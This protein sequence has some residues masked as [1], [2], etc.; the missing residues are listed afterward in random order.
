MVLSSERLRAGFDKIDRDLL[1]LMSCFREVLC[2]LGEQA[3][4]DRLPWINEAP[5]IQDAEVSTSPAMLQAVSISF[6]L[7]NMVE[8]NTSNQM[9]RQAERE[10]GVSAERGLWGW[11]LERLKQTGWKAADV[12]A[13]LPYLRVE[14]VLTAHPTEAKRVTVMEQHRELYVLLIE[15]ENQMYTPM[16]RDQIDNQIKAVLERLWRTGET[17]LEKPTVALERAT[18]LH[19]L[20]NVFPSAVRRSDLNLID[21]WKAVG[22]DSEIIDDPATWPRI[23][24]GTWVGG[25]RDGHPLV[26]PQVTRESL[27]D[28][29]RSALHLLTKELQ[30]LRSKL[31][32]S[33]NLQSPPS[34]LLSALD[35]F[36]ATCGPNAASIANRNPAEPWR[37]YLSFVLERLPPVELDPSEQTDAGR[38]YHYGFELAGDLRR[39]RSSLKKVGAHRVVTA[40]LDPVLR[41]AEVFGFHLATLD[42]R[43][44]SGY[45]DTAI[46]QILVAAGMEET[47][48][49]GWSEAAKIDFFNKH[50]NDAT[51]LLGVADKPGKEAE[52]AIGA[53]REVARH[54]NLYGEEGIGSIILSM[55]RSPADLLALY[56]LA[57]EAGLL[58]QL[59]F[60]LVC[61]VPLVPLLETID[62]LQRGPDILDKFLAHPISQNSHRWHH[63]RNRLLVKKGADD[64]SATMIPDE[65]NRPVQQVMVGYSDS[66]K[67]S[68]ILSSQWNLFTSQSAIAKTAARHGCRVRFFHGRGGTISRGAGPTH[69]F[70]EA[71]P[72]GTIN[73]DIRLTEQ[74]ETIGQKYANTLTASHN[75]TLLLSGTAYCSLQSTRIPSHP[76]KGLDQIFA[77]LADTSRETYQSLLKQPGFIDFYATAT[78]L[79]VLERSRIGSRP[80]RRSGARTLDDLR[81]IPWV[82]SWSQARFF[83]PGWYGV[84]KAL[85]GLSEADFAQLSEALKTWPFL[86]YVMTNVETA[87]CSADRSLMERYASL[88]PDE[89]LRKRF[90]E[91][92]LEEYESVEN[93]LLKLFGTPQAERRPRLDKTLQPRAKA[94]EPL[95][96]RQIELIQQWR[97]MDPDLPQANALIDELLLTVNAIASGLRTTG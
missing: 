3:I 46:D 63:R 24:F 15:L 1:H 81:A 72:S 40:D 71:L 86:N 2:E 13:A 23:R 48:Y 93:H 9:R 27:R 75:L 21:A 91:N 35:E 74:G 62:D 76:P 53:F 33:A 84:G 64:G 85:D 59:D 67:D 82:F 58:R 44:N 57:R 55:T 29:R 89:A 52:G 92:I 36:A 73:S 34:D 66:N 94:L 26:T 19:Y 31:S 70:L 95:H 32:L 51:P 25:D 14:P 8:E 16:E 49:S 43:Q 30:A 61:L 47:G 77:K 39:L 7:L 10:R 20:C 78:P 88:V 69:R 6:Q 65:I 45:H 96:L 80:A 90:M 18:L 56:F 54:I 42:I 87:H 28:L 50:L 4:A 41:M 97:S 11:Y 22:W 60:G 5:A 12:A 38:Y 37:Q 17:L 83:L 68:G 79:D